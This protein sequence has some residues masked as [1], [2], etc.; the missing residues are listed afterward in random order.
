MVLR[1]LHALALL[2]GR[3]AREWT[4]CTMIGPGLQC[5]LSCLSFRMTGVLSCG[6]FPRWRA[7]HRFL[8]VPEDFDDPHGTAAAGAWLARGERGSLGLRSW[9]NG[10]FRMPDAKQR[11][12]PRD[13]GLA[14]RACQQAV[15]PDAVEAVR[16]DMDQEPA[17]ELGRGKPHYLLA[18]AGFDA[19]VFP[20][21]RHDIGIRADQA[22]IR[23][24]DPVGVAAQLLSP[25]PGK[26][27]V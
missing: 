12:D 15:I 17:N 5:A 14:G 27:P 13:I 6:L 11:A 8:A 19:V 21:E 18:V 23:D 1:A 7:R 3:S 10:L 2:S 22:R 25:L 24:G 16:Q 20:A 4:G 9:G 26:P